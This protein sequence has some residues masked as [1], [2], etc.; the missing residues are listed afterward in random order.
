MQVK[1]WKR[2]G[3]DRL[4]MTSDGET[5]IGFWDLTTDQA[6]PESPQHLTAIV[7]AYQDWKAEQTVDSS[8][9]SATRAAE[10][11]TTGLLADSPISA[12]PTRPAP[13]ELVSVG[14]QEP[15]PRP[16]VDLTTNR[17]GAEA[18][19][20]A[21]AARNAAPV[22]SLLA[23]AIGVN[24]DERSW[25]IGADGEELVSAQL[26]KAAKKDPR[27]QFIHAIPV[28]NRGSD[29]DHL[30][31]GPGGIFSVNT[32]HHPKAK[33]WVGGNTFMVDGH[34]QPYIRN[35]RYEATRAA[36]LLSDACGF[37]VHV[38][39][40]IVTVNASDVVIRNAPTG[41]SVTWRRDLAKWLLRHGDI[42]DA[43]T[44]R[45]IYDAAR[46]STTWQP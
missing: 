25:R 18:R 1:R 41:V 8:R 14:A 28:G 17:P 19:Q 5:K 20:Q 4:Y 44:V 9:P 13:S 40:L 37:S 11:A 35:S 46:R 16:W 10:A 27:W 12:A 21:I 45:A 15:A 6:H 26:D 3:K 24:T 29:I 42:L 36:K 43:D 31:I 32:K 23:R 34:K 39:G 33:I 7:A 38:E 22:K 2:Y 30:V